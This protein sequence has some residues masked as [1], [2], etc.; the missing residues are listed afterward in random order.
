MDGMS[1]QP[2]P[3]PPPGGEG[4][5]IDPA[6]LAMGAGQAPL[7]AAMPKPGSTMDPMAAMLGGLTGGGLPPPPP[8]PGPPMGPGGLP[9]GGTM[10]SVDPWFSPEMSGSTLLQGLSR[11]VG[12]PYA[13]GGGGPG[14]LAG[15]GGPLGVN[16][17]YSAGPTGHADLSNI[18]PQDPRMGLEQLIQLIAMA[19]SGAGPDA[20]GMSPQMA[21]GAPGGLLA[22]LPD[23]GTPWGNPSLPRSLM[24]VR[25][26]GSG[27]NFDR[28]NYNVVGS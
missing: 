1:P 13:A 11:A 9:V 2:P 12:D 22:G 28:G 10:P 15:A 23:A 5:G 20:G 14:D 27:V 21:S 26:G 17:P 24:G 19:Q 16:D 6:L 7:P 25:P 3:G 8:P 18:G 4:Q